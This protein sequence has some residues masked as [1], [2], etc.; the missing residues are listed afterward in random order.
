MKKTCATSI[1]EDLQNS[2]DPKRNYIF[3]ED[4]VKISEGKKVSLSKVYGVGTFYSMLS[5]RPRGKHIIRVCGGLACHLANGDTV[6]DKLKEVLH[7]DTG[8]TTADGLFT[9][10]ESSCLGLCSVAP[11]MMI[12]GKPYGR[13]TEEKILEIIKSIKE[14]VIK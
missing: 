11:A 14:G 1:L 2:E 10:E 13:L 12:D 7:V 9:L 4:A 8:E 5:F 6:M 3:F